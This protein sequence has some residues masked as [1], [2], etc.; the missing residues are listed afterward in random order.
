MLLT[1]GAGALTLGLDLGRHA[2]PVGLG[3]DRRDLRR[4]RRRDRAVRVPGAARGRSRSCRRACSRTGSS[5]RRRR[6]RSSSALAMFGAIVYLP[7]FLQVVHEVTPTSSGLRLLPLMAGVLTASILSGRTISKIGRYRPFPIAGTALMT[8]GMWL[9]SP[10]RHR[11]LVP[12]P[13][14]RDARA[15]HRDGA[16]DARA[17]ARRPERGR[18]ARPRHRHLGLDVLPL[19]RRLVRRRDLRRDLREP[20]RLLAAA[21]RCPR[22]PT[23]TAAAP[24]RSSTRARRS[25]TRCR[26]PCTRG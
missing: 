11:H 2:V 26:P 15:R 24:R 4:R 8:V 3:D 12:L 19:D 23:C 22:A 5:T 7:L 17:R 18:A 21:A 20:A 9:L 6:P 10:D 14:G 25:C 16:G 13:L 1:I